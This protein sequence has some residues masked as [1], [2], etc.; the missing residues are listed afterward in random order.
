MYK[1][2]PYKPPSNETRK[3]RFNGYE[4]LL[5]KTDAEL[6]R[7]EEGVIQRYCKSWGMVYIAL[8]STCAVILVAVVLVLLF[9]E[10]LGLSAPTQSST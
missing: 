7:K 5:R 9:L 1:M 2:E 3:P 4:E 6:L 10:R 8:C